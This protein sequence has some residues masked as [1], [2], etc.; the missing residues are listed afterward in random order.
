[1]INNYQYKSKETDLNDL[2]KYVSSIRAQGGKVVFTNGCFDIIHS[3]HVE[4]LRKSRMM[5]D[6]LIVA[7]NSDKSVK[8]LK[9]KNRPINSIESRISVIEAFEFVDQIIVFDNDMPLHLVLEIQPNIYTKGGDYDLENVIGPGYGSDV[10]ESFGGKVILI[11]LL[12]KFSS[13]NIVSNL[14]KEREISKISQDGD[15][16]SATRNDF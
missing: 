4:Y 2:K 11:P 5:G 16:N 14:D 12:D 15:I 13:S 3:G 6:C 9:G 7:I 1:M 10:I 8:K